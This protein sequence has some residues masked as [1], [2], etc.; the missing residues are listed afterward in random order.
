MSA[1]K[2]L[3]KNQAALEM[4]PRIDWEWPLVTIIMPIRN[5]ARF[6][7]SS[8]SSVLAQEYPRERLEVILLDGMSTDGTREAVEAVLNDLNNPKYCSSNK[9]VDPVKVRVVDNEGRIVPTG[10]NKGIAIA[11]GEIVVRVD[12]HT[13]LSPNYVAQSV[14]SLKRTGADVVGGLMTPVGKGLIG[15]TIALAHGLRFGLGG[16][17]FHRATQETEADTVYMGVFRRDVFERVGLFNESLVRNQDIELN[18]RVRQSGGLVIL[19]PE[20]RSLYFCRNTLR[21]LWTQNYKNGLWVPR[22]ISLSPTSLSYRHFV[23]LAFVLALVFS[24]LV[25]FAS[26]IGSVAFMLIVGSYLLCSLV[27]SISAAR[28]NGWRYVL[29]LPIVFLFLHASYGIGSLVGMVK[30]VYD[31]LRPKLDSKSD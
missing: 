31:W 9:R 6:I 20:I 28:T 27:S 26:T 21:A 14:R 23:P 30:I 17:L 25:A 5:E 8:V 12:A 19:S 16:A 7:N 13:V 2:K 1:H 11:Q 3:L 22:T 18:G 10:L 24:G 29:T 15:E 4:P